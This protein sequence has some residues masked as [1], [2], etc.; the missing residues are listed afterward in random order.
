[1]C[2]MSR[3]VVGAVA[4][5]A[6]ASDSPCRAADPDVD[7]VFAAHAATVA[8]VKTLHCRL[9]VEVAKRLD[10]KTGI[11]EGQFVRSGDRERVEMT[12]KGQSYKAVI[13]PDRVLSLTAM[14]GQKP[15]VK[16]HF[17]HIGPYE[18][19]SD[20]WFDLWSAIL[21]ALR[22]GR[23][24]NSQSLRRRFTDL[25]VTVNRTPN[26]LIALD[27]RM[28]P[29]TQFDKPSMNVRAVLD[30]KRNYVVTELDLTRF[31]F[32]PGVTPE[33]SR[34]VRTAGGFKEVVPGCYVP[35]TT[36]FKRYRDGQL[37]HDE[38]AILRD[39][40]VN[41]PVPEAEFALAFSAGT[42]VLDKIDGVE[43]VAGA[44]G[45]PAAAPTPY[46]PGVAFDNSTPRPLPGP[47]SVAEARPAGWWVLPASAALLFA[48]LLIGLAR[49]RRSQA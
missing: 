29:P 32:R 37:Y 43:Y 15:G 20:N 28:P 19:R 11:W 31:I 9:R 10:N 30:P 12:W 40:R 14:P 3:V 25:P 26:G 2:P 21:F 33:A 48:A 18:M 42:Q 4:L 38:R 17:G 49:W 24:I 1:M 5:V 47:P 46:K 7:T 35:T 16:E 6:A 44:D 8:G 36:T 34:D 13:E 27:A 41:Q 45:K 22:G 39:V 23:D